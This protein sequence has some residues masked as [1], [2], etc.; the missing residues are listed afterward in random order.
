MAP[1]PTVILVNMYDIKLNS[2]KRKK[3]QNTTAQKQQASRCS[4]VKQA[5]A[6]GQ[7]QS[8]KTKR[9]VCDTR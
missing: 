9:M 1:F 3:K 6:A 8:L 5:P 2:T 4:E 7:G